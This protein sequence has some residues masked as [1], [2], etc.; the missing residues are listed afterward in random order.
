M[1][2]DDYS[3]RKTTRRIVASQIFKNS[4]E[5]F[6]S[7]TT[8]K[9]GTTAYI[10]GRL[11]KRKKDL[12][13][14]IPHEGKS[15]R[16]ILGNSVYGNSFWR[17]EIYGL[18]FYNHVLKPEQVKS[19]F[20]TWSKARD[21][22]FAKKEKPFLL[23]LFDER[24]G[25]SSFDHT[26]GNHHLNIPKRVHVLKKRMLSLPWVDLKLD[27]SFIQ[28]FI[29]NLVGFIPLGFFLCATLFEFGGIFQNRV[30]LVAVI[31][32]FTISLLIEISQA[33][34]PSRSSQILDLLLNTSGALIGAIGFRSTIMITKPV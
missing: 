5:A 15:T 13:L 23:F 18:A 34:M 24:E 20:D 25:I 10:D 29:V 14:K 1:N 3:N 17:G 2:G 4:Q 7:I 6:L 22:S 21:F 32:S 26:N 30:I 33:W 19:H 27:Q 9:E 16:L 28:D 12:K 31:F 11:I 8:G